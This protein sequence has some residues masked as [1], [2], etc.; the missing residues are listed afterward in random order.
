MAAKPLPKFHTYFFIETHPK[1]MHQGCE[2]KIDMKHQSVQPLRKILEKNVKLGQGKDDFIISIYAGDIMA[3]L[4][5]DKEIKTLQGKVRTFPVKIALKIQKNKFEGTIN[6]FLDFDC[7]M[8]FV[9]FEPIKK[10]IGKPIDPPPQIELAPFQ[11]MSLF[12]EALL[13]SEKR[14]I[15]DPTYLEFLRFGVNLLK[16]MPTVPFRLFL[17][18]YEKILNSE[19]IPLLKAILD[20]FQIKKMEPP[21]TME[22]LNIFQEPL[23]TIYN[24]PTK[25]VDNMQK[26]PNGNFVFCL[27]KFYTVNIFYNSTLNNYQKIESI[28]IDLRDKNPFDNLILA[29]LFLSEFNYYY[30]NLP[31]NQDIKMSLIDS[32]IQASST[33]ENLTT[34]FSMITEYIQGDFNTI[35]LIV[36]KNY[37]KINEICVKSNQSLKINDYII[38]KYDDNLNDIQ[39]NLIILGNYKVNCNFLAVLFKLETWD[40]YLSDGRNPQFLEFLKSHLLRTSVSCEE[41]ILVLNYFIKYTKK[42]FITTLEMYTKNYDRLEVICQNQKKYINVTNYIEPRASDNIQAIQE[43]LNFIVARKIKANFETLFFN[44]NIWLFYINNGF[45]QE[46]LLFLEQKLFEGA[47]YFDDIIDCLTYA[48]TLR[49]NKFAPLL[50]VINNNFT[51]INIFVENKKTSIDISK[52]F[53]IDTYNDNLDEIYQLIYDLINR[54]SSVS[55]KTFHFK[56]GIWEPYSRTKNLDDLRLIRKIIIKLTQMDKDLTEKDIQLGKKIHDVGFQYIRDGRLTGDKLL[57][58]LGIEEAFYVEGQINDIIATN[59]YQQK[60]LDEHLLSINYL[61]EENLALKVRV[62]NCETE[63]VNL[64]DENAS[65]KSRVRTLESDV[66]DLYSRVRSCESDISSLRWRTN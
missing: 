64:K 7:F 33:Y 5:K 31:I 52:Y 58:F 60:Q 22:E 49:N 19:D 35:L 40:L 21:K 13:M 24:N 32:Y 62:R 54:E 14:Q 48:T 27:V 66:R 11:Y 15:K 57:S 16:S 9:K 2:I 10:L 20:Y 59:I 8:R 38:Q 47:L 61:K 39:N 37:D 65:L 12:N 43:H 41:L 23:I 25:Y 45:N 1:S 50:K 17:L 4:L 42:D 3:D 26:I 51:K 28:M 46:F 56:I 36:N 30:R 55:Y 44:V 34:A 18:I 63:I 6:P 29:K 53:T